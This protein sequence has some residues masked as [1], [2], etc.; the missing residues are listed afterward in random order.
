MGCEVFSFCSHGRKLTCPE[1][2]QS[3]EP[4]L[5]PKWDPPAC[6]HEVAGEDAKGAVLGVAPLLSLTPL[7]SRFLIANHPLHIESMFHLY[8]GSVFSGVVLLPSDFTG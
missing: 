2:A 1:V 6:L 8:L 7:G 4:K 5:E 3:T